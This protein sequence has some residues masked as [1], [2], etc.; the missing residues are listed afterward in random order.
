MSS[1][2]QLAINY[3]AEIS[4]TALPDFDKQ[5]TDGNQS[6]PISTFE[7]ILEV[8][9]H[10]KLAAQGLVKLVDGGREFFRHVDWILRRFGFV[11]NVD[12]STVYA[13]VD[14]I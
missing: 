11:G 7:D 9:L 14:S 5:V 13:S 10:V 4:T 1:S 3:H 2:A 6:P 12:D 8:L